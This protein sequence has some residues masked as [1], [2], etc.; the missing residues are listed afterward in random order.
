MSTEHFRALRA[1]EIVSGLSREDLQDVLE[2]NPG[3]TPL[4]LR[5]L[6]VSGMNGH[7]APLPATGATL[8]S[9]A[10]SI[11]NNEDDRVSIDDAD[12]ALMA[13]SNLTPRH[14]VVLRFIVSRER[15]SSGGNPSGWSPVRIAN[16]IDIDSD[17][18][19]WCLDGLVSAG[20][21]VSASDFFG[22]TFF[23]ATDLSEAVTFAS[24]VFADRA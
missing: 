3:L 7:P 13:M 9:A 8:G 23:W 5:V 14:F 24:D 1:A 12:Q 6:W 11:V 17:R 2:T 19:A 22:G 20:L 15:P 4:Y 21:T 10:R 16:E 18:A